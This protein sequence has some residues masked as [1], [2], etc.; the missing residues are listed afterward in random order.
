MKRHL[1]ECKICYNFYHL[2]QM[3]NEKNNVDICKNCK[4]KM[5]KF[6]PYIIRNNNFI[7]RI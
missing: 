2:Y 1:Y 7:R 5:D 3:V 4:I 6:N